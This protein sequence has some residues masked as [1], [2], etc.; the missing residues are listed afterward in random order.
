MKYTHIISVVIEVEYQTSFSGARG[1]HSRKVVL[2]L[3]DGQS[4]IQRKKT[5]PEAKKLKSSGVQ[6]FVI[7]VGGQHI[8]GIQEMAE[9]ASFPPAKFLFR[10]KKMGDFLEVVKLAIKQVS[11][12]QYKILERYKPSCP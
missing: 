12:G 9:V 8:H 7:A 4:N 5:V 10:V 2:L 1:A 6:V 11:P 3:T